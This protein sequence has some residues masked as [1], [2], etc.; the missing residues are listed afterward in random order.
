VTTIDVGQF[1]STNENFCTLGGG[2]LISTLDIY[3]D[4]WNYYSSG[5]AGIFGFGRNS[6]IWDIMGIDSASTDARYYD[7]ELTNFNN[8]TFADSSYIQPNEYSVMNVGGFATYYTSAMSSTSFYPA[9]TGSSLLPLKSFGFGTTNTT[10]SSSYYNSLLNSDNDTYTV[11]T[12]TSI[13]ALNFRGLGLPTAEFKSFA[14]MLQVITL[15]EATCLYNKG[16]YC[17]LSSPCE[18]YNKVNLWDYDFKIQFNTTEDE[19]Y[20]RVPL[21]SF[22][23][24]YE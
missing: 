23:A 9:T 22:A 6:P 24:N 19:N 4:N 1:Y 3:D 11:Y 10:N 14:N 16:G 18:Y 8:W 13:L 20:L 5:S 7:V 21:A 17:V 2:D 15:G 12:N